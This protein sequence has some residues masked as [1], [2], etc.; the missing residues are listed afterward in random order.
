MVRKKTD[1]S[2]RE[3]TTAIK[4]KC[5][6][7]GSDT[8]LQAKHEAFS[9]DKAGVAETPEGK[10]LINVDAGF[11]GDRGCGSTGAI[12]RDSNGGFIAAAYRFLPY[13]LDT[14]TAEACALKEG[15]ELAKQIGCNKFILQTDCMAVVETIKEEGFSAIAAATIYEECF[16]VW[17]YMMEATI[18]HCH[19]EANEG[20]A[21]DVALLSN[22]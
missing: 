10:L 4:I 15:L 21:N 22:E 20:L 1:C 17:R 16:I 2:R 14:P 12:I 5:L 3:R 8:K 11:C 7:L 18:E 6:N 19:R 13:V 9:C